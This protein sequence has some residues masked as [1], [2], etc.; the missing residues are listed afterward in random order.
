MRLRSWRVYAAAEPR[1]TTILFIPPCAVP[2]KQ[3]G[4]WAAGC[5]QI[6]LRRCPLC[7]HDSIVGHGRRS[8]QAHDEHHDRIRIRRGRC[9]DCRKTFTFLPSLS[10]P[11]TH[12]SLMSR[13]QAL[14]RRFEEHRSWEKSVPLLKDPNH[15]PDSSTLR[16]WARGL[17]P[18]QPAASFLC[19]TLAHIARSM[20]AARDKTSPQ[21]AGSWMIPI[22]QVLWPRRC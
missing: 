3:D 16:R 9:P 17:N 4:D 7:D 5:D 6:I 10:L 13:G 14:R 15:Q 19:Q 22:V 12:Y 18:S 11:Y 2:C 20:A 8:K 21:A 1:R